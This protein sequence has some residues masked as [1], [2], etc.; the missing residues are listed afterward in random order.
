MS[1]QPGKNTS[2]TDSVSA[3]PNRLADTFTSLMPQGGIE[4]REG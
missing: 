3:S 4:I 2:E 1:S